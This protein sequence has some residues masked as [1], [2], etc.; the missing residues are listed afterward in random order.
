MG[1]KQNEDQLSQVTMMHVLLH[2]VISIPRQ[3][4][5]IYLTVCNNESSQIMLYFLILDCLEP[6]KLSDC[7][8]HCLLLDLLNLSLLA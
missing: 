2:N 5:E 1:C 8:Y 4:W 6:Q 3:W 7:L